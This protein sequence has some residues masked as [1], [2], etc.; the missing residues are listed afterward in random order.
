VSSRDV[1]PPS[2]KDNM[3][4]TTNTVK[5]LMNYQ[6]VIVELELEEL[7]TFSDP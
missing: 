6:P 2:E 7:L 1:T 5:G 3:D 4:N